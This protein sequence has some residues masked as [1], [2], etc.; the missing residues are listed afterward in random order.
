MLAI[1]LRW[2]Q[3]L[4]WFYSSL[5]NKLCVSYVTVC[6]LGV[7]FVMER[8]FTLKICVS[9]ST[10]IQSCISMIRILN[11]EDTMRWLFYLVK[12]GYIW[13]FYCDLKIEWLNSDLIRHFVL[14]I[15]LRYIQVLSCFYWSQKQ[16]LYVRYFMV[17]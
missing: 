8:L 15:I 14:V 10:K 16:T 12:Y 1:L 3:V 17:C 2:I 9:S 4:L 7:H 6:K 13:S 11:K 5:K